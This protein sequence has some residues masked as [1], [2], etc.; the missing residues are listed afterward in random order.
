MLE[1]EKIEKRI[2]NMKKIYE[3]I[4]EVFD[5]IPDSIPKEKV[6]QLKNV[7]LGDKELKNLIDGVDSH[8]PPKIFL[9]GRT[10][11][12]KSSL[13]NALCS[14]YVAFVDDVKSCT[15]EADIHKCVYE[16]RVLMEVLDTRGIAESESLNSEVSAE[17]M[18][19]KQVSEFSPDIAILMLN[20]THR[21][22]IDSDVSFVKNIVDNYKKMNG[23]TLPVIVVVNKCDE[24]TPSRFKLPSEYTQVKI[25]K[26]EQSVRYFKGIVDRIG[27]EIDDIVAVSSLLEWQSADGEDVNFEDINEMSSQDV[28]NLKISFDGRYN[29]DV[30]LNVLEKN[31]KDVEAQMGLKMAFRLT[32]VVHK[33]AK[34]LNGIFSGLAGTVALTP[35]PVSDIYILLTLQS[36]MVSMIAA[37]SGRDV[38]FDTAKEFVLSLGGIVGAGYVFKLVAQQGAKLLNVLYPGAGSVV[39]ASVASMGTSSIGNAAI[40]YYIDEKSKKEVKKD[41]K[42]SSNCSE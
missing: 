15:K 35:I 16:N 24:M 11:V 1:S 40:A 37:L 8:R 28:E 9:I 42:E 31:I 18:L 41:F 17:D 27:L 12:G 39:S 36:V 2:K 32:E 25:N 26:I 30:L 5:N 23:I 19:I 4:N 13:I 10:G 33:I 7:I 6:D 29:L 3:N 22:D 14:A 38:N 20:C 21:D 34:R